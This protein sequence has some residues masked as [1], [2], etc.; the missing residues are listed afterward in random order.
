M[1]SYPAKPTWADGLVAAVLALIAGA[2]FF[3]L[4]PR[5]GQALTARVTVD[6]KEVACLTLAG[7]SREYTVPDLPYPLTVETENG[8]ARI[9]TSGCPTQ[10]CVHQG[11]T[12][13]AGAQLI[14]LPN[15]L[16]VSLEGSGGVDAVLG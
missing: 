8:A 10:D 1:K 14:C 6:G 4:W 11:W 2:L 13:Q 5:Q 9:K 15:R 16:V 7:P 3:A 12:S